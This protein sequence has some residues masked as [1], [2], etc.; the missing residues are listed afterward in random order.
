MRPGGL[1]LADNVLTL[2]PRVAVYDEATSSESVRALR[3]YNRL[4]AT[5]PRLLGT[6]LPVGEGLSVAWK[7]TP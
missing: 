6:I 7:V 4:V 2:G 1:I 5:D 3:R